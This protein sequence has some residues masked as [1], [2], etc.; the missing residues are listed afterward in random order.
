MD[1]VSAPVS[2]AIIAGVVSIIAAFTTSVVT[3]KAVNKRA[4]VDEKLARLKGEID[5]E[6]AAQK[7]WLDNQP[8]FAAERVANVLLND[9]EW[10]VRSLGIIKHHL[11]GFEDDELR[12][13]LVRA[14]AIRW[15]DADGQE[16]WGL[17]SRNRDL[18]SVVRLS[19]RVGTRVLAPLQQQQQHNSSNNSSSSPS[20]ARANGRARAVRI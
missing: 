4:L 18:L 5:R 3:L 14:G 9:S 10:T 2:A 6:L 20:V 17:L 19:S 7:V 1:W 16:V 15:L 11:G 8:S 13:I 12:R